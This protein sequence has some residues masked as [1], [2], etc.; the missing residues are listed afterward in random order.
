MIDYHVHTSLCN[1]AEGSMEAYIRKAVEIGLTDICF[2]DHLTMRPAETSHSMALSEVPFYFQALQ[3]LKQK[4]KGKIK[5]KI[6]LEIDFNPIYIDS[7]RE[8]I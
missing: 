3:R 6:G 4:Y 1:H 8:I 2:L 7:L 5:V